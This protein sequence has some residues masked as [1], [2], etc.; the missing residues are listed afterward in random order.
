MNLGSLHEDGDSRLLLGGHEGVAG[1]QRP[2]AF[3]EERDVTRRVTRSVD[4]PQ[5]E[6]P[7]TLKSAGRGRTRSPTSTGPLGKVHDSEAMIPPPTVGSGGGY[8]ERPVR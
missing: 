7:G 2:V 6:R 1:D 4:P 8:G 5:P 3:A